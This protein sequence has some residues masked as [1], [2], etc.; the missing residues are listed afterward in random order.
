MA[1]RASRPL[2]ERFRTEPVRGPALAIA[3]AIVWIAGALYCS[4]Y[5]R[6]LSGLDNWPGGLIWSAV[7]VLPWLALFEWSKSRSGRLISRS[8]VRLAAAVLLTGIISLMLGRVL[9]SV[10][11]HSTPLALSTLRRLPAAGIGLLLILWSRAGAIPRQ[12]HVETEASLASLAPSI[13]W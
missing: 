5:E 13:D 6:L 10:D 7:A 8:S 9:D 3:A 12:R 1:S 2:L 11:G 4:G